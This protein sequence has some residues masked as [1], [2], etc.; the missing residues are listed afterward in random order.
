VLVVSRPIVIG[1][2]AAQRITSPV[3]GSFHCKLIHA[4]SVAKAMPFSLLRDM[5]FTVLKQ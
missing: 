1:S 5:K 2:G 3:L 4:R